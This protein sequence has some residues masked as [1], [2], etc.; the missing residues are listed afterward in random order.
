M[1]FPAAVIIA[2][3]V[4]VAPRLTRRNK[5]V[6]IVLDFEK[7][8]L[9]LYGDRRNI[10]LTTD[11]VSKGR[12]RKPMPRPIPSLGDLE[13]QVLRLIWREQPCSERTISDLVLAGKP[14]ARTTV[15]K[16]IQRLEE[17]GC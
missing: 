5:V 17:K 3:N 9:T 6:P 16:T 13:I 11:A 4:I 7:K 1:I 8:S 14:I 10:P 12:V 2:E 15:L